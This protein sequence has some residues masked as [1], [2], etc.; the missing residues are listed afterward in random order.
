M[1]AVFRH[2][3]GMYFT[4]LS[5][6]V[7]GAFM[8][9]FTGIYMMVY[10]L[11]GGY[12]NF[13]Y[14]P[15]GMSFIF[16]IIVP[17]LSMRVLAEEKKQKTDQLLYSLPL[18]MT[19]VI[20]GKYAAMLVVLLIPTAIMCVYPL[21]LS[22]YGDVYFPAAY[23]TVLAFFLLGAALL[24]IAIAANILVGAIPSQYTQLDATSNDLYSVSEQTEAVVKGLEDDVEVYWIVRD[25]QEDATL[26]VLLQRYASMS[27]HLTVTQKD[28]DVYPTFVQQY[29][30]SVT[31][32]SLVVVCGD[33]SR[34]VDYYDIYEYD[35]SNY[36]YSGSY[37]VS[38]AGES[39]LTSAIDYVT[40]DDLPK[41]YTLTGHGE[42]ELSTEYASA[43]EGENIQ[44]EELSLLTLEAVPEDADAIMI[45][46]PQ[47]DISGEEADMLSAWL[48]E[49]G[50]LLLIT[51]PLESGEELTNLLGVM[52]AYGV[53]AEPGIVIEGSQDHYAWGTP[54]YL[55]PTENS[56]TITDPLR[57]D[58]Y[59]ILLPIAQGLTVAD[60]LPDGV[61]VTE[62]LT[63]SSSAFS[64]IAG[65][66]LTTY[67]KEDDDIDGPFALAVAIEAESDT[68]EAAQIVWISSASV[69]DDSANQMVSGGNR[70]LFLNALNW[71][72]GQDDESSLTIRSK[73]LSY[74]YLT[75]PTSTVSMLTVLSI[76]II[77]LC[78]LGVG[79]YIHIRRKHR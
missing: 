63:T 4:G 26:Q 19:Q 2:E 42:S 17:I 69:L 3:T 18:S 57:T 7:F 78:Y 75:I 37:D 40:S 65:Y 46:A 48:Q 35:M 14:V 36:Y 56:H 30:D 70:D 28:P 13:E 24:A 1:R 16:L 68:D 59:Y 45:Y 79:I 6:Y 52:Q 9:L 11:K 55:L 27:D 10:N 49:G 54:Y 22:A 25:G 53:S 67:E 71:L 73:S 51:D 50:K 32:N 12:T 64:K 66:D 15:A 76:G 21:I 39:A 43:V 62:L 20:L 77:P 29:T 41:V 8:L 60:E 58:G 5:G 47:S 74:D 31:D 72:C 38:F 33:R 44:T 61:S 34:Y 23:G